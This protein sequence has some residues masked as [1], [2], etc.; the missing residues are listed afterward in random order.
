[1]TAFGHQLTNLGQQ[2]RGE[3]PDVVHHGLVLIGVCHQAVTE[4]LPQGGVFVGK[5]NDAVVIALQPLFECSEHQDTPQ[6]HPW[7]AG[8]FAGFGIHLGIQQLEDF[9]SF[10]NVKIQVLQSEQQGRNVVS[11]FWIDNDITDEGAAQFTLGGFD[12]SHV[13]NLKIGS[14]WSILGLR[15][16]FWRIMAQIR[17]I[18]DA[19]MNPYA[20]VYVD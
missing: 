20:F 14:Q 7:A 6:F 3:Q 8:V 10:F 16:E 15:G 18:F 17:A 9:L 1:M 5:L 13:F 2:L 12:F 19:G 4:H 11:G